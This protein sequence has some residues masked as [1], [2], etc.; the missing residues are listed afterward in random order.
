MSRTFDLTGWTADLRLPI[1]ALSLSVVLAITFVASAD[2]Q[3]TQNGVLIGTVTDDSGE[4]MPGTTVTAT[5]EALLAP[6]VA[7]TAANGDYAIRGL[8]PGLYKVAFAMEG[9]L[10]VEREARIELGRTSRVDS[11]MA[12]AE[13]QD[14][15]IVTDEYTSP[16]DDVQGSTNLTSEVIDVLPTAR[17]PLTVAQLAP[18]VNDRTELDQLSISG[19]QGYDNLVMVDGVDITF[20]IFG[21]VGGPFQDEVGLYIEEA[22]ADTQVVSSRVSAEFG[23]FAGG[24]VNVIT[25]RGGNRF[26][27]SFRIDLSDPSWQDETPI[28]E[29][30][31]IRREGDRNEV[32]SGTLGGPVVK[33]R[34]WFFLA[35]ATTDRSESGVYPFTG[36][37]SVADFENTRLQLKLSGNLADKHTL[38]FVALDNDTDFVG[39]NTGLEIDP[40]AEDDFSLPHENRVLRYSGVLGSNTL[41][42][43]QYA[44]RDF[45]TVGLGGSSPRLE[46]SPFLSFDFELYNAPAFSE[47]DPGQHFEDEQLA[48]SVSWFLASDRAGSHDLKFGFELFE[49]T[50]FGGRSQS[51]SDFFFD[52][53][54][55]TDVEGNAVLDAQGR[56]QP[57]FIPFA[58]DTVQFLADPDAVLTL[59]TDSFYVN[60]LWR[61]NDHWSFNLGFRYEELSGDA[62]D[63]G[64]LTDIDAFLPRLSATYDPKGDGR[65]R[66]TFGAADYAGKANA[67]I[68]KR[69]SASRNPD[70]LVLLYAGPP[71]AGIDFAPGFDLGN[72]FPVFLELPAANVSFE[73]DLET[74]RVS[75]YTLSAGMQLAR[76]G[77]LE[78][79]YVEREYHDFVEDFI[80]FSNGTVTVDDSPVG[81]VTLDRIVLSN[82]DLPKRDYRAIQLL[83]R[84]RF[85]DKWRIDGNWTWQLENDGNFVGE[86]PGNP[87]LQSLIGDYPEMLVPERNFPMGKLPGYQ[88][89]KLR[90]WA[91]YDQPLGNAG[92]LNVSGIFS[93][94]SPLT[95]SLS[96]F[97]PL[98]PTQAARDPGYQFP[99]TAAPI[100]F[101]PRGSEEFNS[102]SIFDL[103]TTYF[104]PRWKT[105]EPWIK[106]EIRNLF[107]SSTARTFNT[108]IAP[109]FNGP[110]DQNGIP[111]TFVRSPVFGEPL[112]VGDFVEPRAYLVSIGIRG[113]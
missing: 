37:P 22:I 10:T 113:G 16:L 66:F 108:S 91:T 112:S 86:N 57:L 109:N 51:G 87:A 35:G 29:E 96:T 71:G 26:K 53:P 9:M 88:E 62:S 89:H 110:V 47:F 79:I 70:I 38:E 36:L 50:Q 55:L 101:G 67:E 54:F 4:R 24:V 31:G 56:V 100:F 3:G 1:S 34:L 82:S 84:Y 98:S 64:G 21:N 107:G 25:K 63:A 5:S 81:P 27:G 6:R 76:G 18:G 13:A 49:S 39:G 85:N 42:E 52:A 20:G 19:A 60:D 46:D 103:A 44:M 106:V 75:E 7:Y 104:G 73:G 32:F 102:T 83:G 94:D 99:P 77:F 92:H 15:I 45:I 40:R 33:D 23:R 68:F 65:Y 95:Y 93:Y 11:T 78:A 2:A 14:T 12:L 41:L 30:F 28:E 59:N 17:D 58:T 90:V 61:L 8:P 74:T 48:G 97:G 105:L 80:Q 43:A 69:V 111:T 72:Y